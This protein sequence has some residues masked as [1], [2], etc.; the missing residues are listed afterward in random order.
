M[1]ESL[2]SHGLLHPLVVTKTDDGKFQLVAG[3]RRLRAATLLGWSEVPITLLEDLS[4]LQTKAIELEENI[5]RSDLTSYEE[6]ELYRQLD[7]LK[8]KIYGEKMPGDSKGE[9]WTTE[10]TAELL[11][12]DRSHLSKQIA[13]AKLLKENPT[14]KASVEK[15]PINTAMKKAKLILEAERL[16]RINKD[17]EVSV[18]LKLGDCRT[19]VKNIPNGSIDLILTD[20]PYGVAEI[21]DPTDDGYKG[22]VKEHDNMSLEGAIQVLRDVI[23]DL[24]RV[25]KPSGH[26]YI[27]HSIDLYAPLMGMLRE[28]GFLPEVSPIV[29]D[30]MRTT[31]PFRG[32][33]YACCYELIL[34]GH[35]PPRE[36]M[37]HKA[38]KSILQEKVP[39]A[40]G[41]VH[42]FQKPIPLLKYLIEQS[43]NLGET[44]LD[45]FAGSGTTVLA[46]KQCGRE[47]IGFELNEENYY[48]AL[49]LFEGAASA[50][51]RLEAEVTA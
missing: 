10:K 1:M 44:I 5:Q 17:K 2:K 40:A 45:P 37:L 33:A 7:E 20:V 4:P 27:F 18:D 9:G 6:I 41:K 21:N 36:K 50:K 8:R 49:T 25:L 34:F 35:K 29:W 28:V 31:T 38:C 13:F 24:F 42:V 26:F 11:G 22:L 51:G 3:E 39:S 12:V 46:A 30:K 32:Y 48:N 47:A 14:L 43:T 19:L 16:Q 15:L 23:P